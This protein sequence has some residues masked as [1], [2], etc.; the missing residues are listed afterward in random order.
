MFVP[1]WYFRI[2]EFSGLLNGPSVQKRKSVPALFVQISKILGLS[3]PGLANHH[4]IYKQ[5]AANPN[6]ISTMF[7]SFALLQSVAK[8]PKLVMCW[9]FLLNA[10]LCRWPIRKFLNTL[11]MT[12]T[13][14]PHQSFCD[15]RLLL[16]PILCQSKVA[17]AFSEKNPHPHYYIMKYNRDWKMK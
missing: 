17:A 4:C 12:S 15:V 9:Y 14:W 8:L 6:Q 2:N 5:W 10:R 7:S 1:G 3:E 16:Q 11:A 13:M